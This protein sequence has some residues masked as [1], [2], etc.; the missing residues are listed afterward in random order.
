MNVRDLAVNF[1]IKRLFPRDAQRVR[2]S[3]WIRH[4]MTQFST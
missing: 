2:L 3:V 4:I 1:E